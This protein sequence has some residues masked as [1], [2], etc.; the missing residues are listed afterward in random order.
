[1]G[2]LK[3]PA[4]IITHHHTNLAFQHHDWKMLAFDGIAKYCLEGLLGEA[5]QD[6]MF[7]ALD[8]LSAA[9]T[10]QVILI[11]PGAI[12]MIFRQYV[13]LLPSVVHN[14]IAV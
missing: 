2:Q 11:V 1:M 13:A 12:A 8:A 7:R 5:Q 3:V 14:A 9:T 4:L 10:Y 6:A